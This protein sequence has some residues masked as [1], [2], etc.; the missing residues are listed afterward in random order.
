MKVFIEQ[1]FLEERLDEFMREVSIYQIKL[2]LHFIFS[3]S[4]CF[5]DFHFKYLLIRELLHISREE[6]KICGMTC[7]S[8]DNGLSPNLKLLKSV[9]F[10]QPEKTMCHFRYGR[11]FQHD[12][13]QS[14]V[15]RKGNTYSAQC[16]TQ[17]GKR[18]IYHCT[19]TLLLKK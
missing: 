19:R 14:V 11:I 13:S 17:V 4:F 1:D 7:S 5:L 6:K 10:A 15:N 16:L 2:H 3:Y 9:N 12:I 18:R 8:D